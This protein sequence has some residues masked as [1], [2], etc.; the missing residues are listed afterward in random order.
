MKL[1]TSYVI[2]NSWLIDFFSLVFS[3]KQ[4]SKLQLL[5]DV[6]LSLVV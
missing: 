4:L 5:Y 3:L 6:E 2:P 1:L